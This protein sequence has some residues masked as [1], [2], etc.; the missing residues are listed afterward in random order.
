MKREAR[1]YAKERIEV[2]MFGHVSKLE[3][4]KSKIGITF[5]EK[6]ELIKNGE[7]KFILPKNLDKLAYIYDFFDFSEYEKRYKEK[8]GILDNRINKVRE[9]ARRAMDELYLGDEKVAYDLIQQFR[10]M[11]F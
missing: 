4:E 8:I 9:E 7:V 2:I 10:E 1:K 6:I 5:K 11:T 3:H